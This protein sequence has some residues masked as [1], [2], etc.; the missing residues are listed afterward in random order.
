[1]T[2]GATTSVLRAQS[3]HVSIVDDLG[4][5]PSQ[6]TSICIIESWWVMI[7]WSAPGQFF[8]HF[9]RDRTS[10]TVESSQHMSTSWGPISIH[11]ASSSKKKRPSCWWTNPPST[12]ITS[13]NARLKSFK[14]NAKAKTKEARGPRHPKH[15]WYCLIY[16][17]VFLSNHAQSRIFP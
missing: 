17:H 4:L 16:Y 3:F 11:L 9:R 15:V 2:T 1:M 14:Q 13:A 7:S 10:W 12:C 6:E 8:R 5:P